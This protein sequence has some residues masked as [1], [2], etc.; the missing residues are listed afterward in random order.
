MRRG[1]RVIRWTTTLSVVVL[2][3]IAAIVSYRHMFVLVHR[4]GETSWTAVLLPVSVD[5]MIVASSMSLLASSRQGERSGVL[6]W[7]LL[8][9]GSAASLAANVAVAEPSAVGRLIAAWPSAALIGSYEL[10]M[11]QIRRT[12]VRGR[13]EQAVASYGTPTVVTANDAV[14]YVR[15]DD[16]HTDPP[17]KVPYGAQSVFEKRSHRV[18]SRGRRPGRVAGRPRARRRVMVLIAAQRIIASEWAGF[19]S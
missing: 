11:R 18:Y 16:G 7:V 4:Y 8:I 1:D 10:L 15:P 3:G 2:A 17:L 14:S 9:V 6:P 13:P 12:V 19:R 5:G